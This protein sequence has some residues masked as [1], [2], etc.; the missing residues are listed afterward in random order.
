MEHW[1]DEFEHESIT[2]ENRES[3]KTAMGKY[4]TQSDATVGG[5]NAQ[6]EVG[7]PFRIPET[8]DKLDDAGKAEFTS[9]AH[10]ALGITH[11]KSVEDLAD[12]DMRAGMAEGS[13]VK[14]DENIATMLKTLAVE[15]KWPKS[16]VQDI[17]GLY[18]GKLTEYATEA[19]AKQTE[20]KKLADAK[21]CNEALIADPDFGS[22]EKV[23]EESQL[24]MRAVRNNLGL[25]EDE[26]EEF[27][28]LMA[29]TLLTKKKPVAKA[30]L[31]LLAPLA[32]EGSTDGGIGGGGSAAAKGQ[33]PYQWKKE[34]WPKTPDS[35]GNE[36]D[37]WETQD[38]QMRKL[39]G[40]K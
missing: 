25:T 15:K 17:V 36:K 38:I 1:S 14:V 13:E 30:M 26:A 22:E 16:V 12:I 10:K 18:N 8:L 29:D 39:A 35:W 7:K 20:D 32:R 3:F 27:G 2:D 28:Q 11:A 4:A 23:K 31:K 5:F 37:T 19:L 34:R 21:A 33:S 24:A 6:K 9:Q 40:I